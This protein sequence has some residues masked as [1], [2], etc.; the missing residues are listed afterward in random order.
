MGTLV[1]TLWI[2]VYILL[3]LWLVIIPVGVLVG[4][5]AAFRRDD[6]KGWGKK[7]WGRHTPHHT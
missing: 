2:I 6:W 4:S 7:G 3:T 5:F 1:A